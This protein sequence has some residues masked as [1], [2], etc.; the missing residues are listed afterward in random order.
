MRPLWVF[1]VIRALADLNRAALTPTHLHPRRSCSPPYRRLSVY[2]VRPN[3]VARAALDVIGFELVAVTL[4]GFTSIAPSAGLTAAA[5][6]G[7]HVQA[8]S[9]L[10]GKAESR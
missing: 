9:R 10:A 5:V 1:E 8:F 3:A 7:G 4:D 2:G 6:D